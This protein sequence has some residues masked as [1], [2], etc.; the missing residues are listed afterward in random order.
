MIDHFVQRKISSLA[1]KTLHEL[2]TCL[3]HYR[4]IVNDIYY[5]FRSLYHLNFHANFTQSNLTF[6]YYAITITAIAR[7]K[8]LALLL[9]RKDFT[10]DSRGLQCQCDVKKQSVASRYLCNVRR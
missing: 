4:T 2:N 10:I 8:D 7:I 3:N 9:P 1:L 6:L 5:V